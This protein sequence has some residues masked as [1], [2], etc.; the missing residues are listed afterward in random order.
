MRAAFAKLWRGGEKSAK[1][2]VGINAD[3]SFTR[4]TGT[5]SKTERHESGGAPDEGVFSFFV[6]SSLACTRASCE[7]MEK[8]SALSFYASVSGG[9]NEREP[10]SK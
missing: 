8:N 3:K 10:Q 4:N 1:P 7:C 5:I 6:Y 9:G 2:R